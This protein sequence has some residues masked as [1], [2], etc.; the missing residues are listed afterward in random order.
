MQCGAQN[1][2][3]LNCVTG[4]PR[5]GE[6]FEP[7]PQAFITAAATAHDNAAMED[8]QTLASGLDAPGSTHAVDEENPHPG[9]KPSQLVGPYE[10]G[11][12]EYV[13]DVA[14]PLVEP[15]AHTVQGTVSKRCV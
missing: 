3:T 13:A 7:K 9:D 14:P 15:R 5:G 1:G 11:S 12:D 4:D 6:A 8:G 10:G 2:A